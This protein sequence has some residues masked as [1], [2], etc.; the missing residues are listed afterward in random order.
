MIKIA[1]QAL[2]TTKKRGLDSRY[3]VSQLQPKDFSVVSLTTIATPHRGAIPP[4][5]KFI[6]HSAKV[7]NRFCNRGLRF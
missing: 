4:L 1:D 5:D 3:M 6:G 2:V 7:I